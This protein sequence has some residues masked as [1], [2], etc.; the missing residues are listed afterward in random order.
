MKIDFGQ[1]AFGQYK[2]KAIQTL[3]LEHYDKCPES[4]R[5]INAT[6]YDISNQQ[7]GKQNNTYMPLFANA[8]NNTSTVGRLLGRMARISDQLHH[9]LGPK[10]RRKRHISDCRRRAYIGRRFLWVQLLAVSQKANPFN[11]KQ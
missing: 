3:G 1:L 5:G 10:F 9:A 8:S 4:R 11:K 7:S 6:L 2:A